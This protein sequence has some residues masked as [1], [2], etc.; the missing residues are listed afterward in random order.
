MLNIRKVGEV[1]DGAVTSAKI[2]DGAVTTA[3]VVSD[4]KKHHYVGDEQD[5]FITG[6]TEKGI[7]RFLFI[8]NSSTF[9]F[10]T[11]IICATVKTSNVS[12]TATLKVYI[13]LPDNNI[14]EN[15]E[16]INNPTPNLTL[17][18]TSTTFEVKTGSIDISELNSG[19]H[20][21]FISLV[22]T[23]A[24]QTAYNDLLEFVGEVN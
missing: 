1:A 19:R 22:S 5:V 4:L 7:K 9:D 15:Y 21:V 16:I 14:N 2:A 6:T 17:T 20:S 18:S 23:D 3:K 10:K 11:A 13:D 12:A 24:A 8:K